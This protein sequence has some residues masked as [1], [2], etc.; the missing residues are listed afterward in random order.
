MDENETCWMI[1]H[2]IE[3]SVTCFFPRESC[4]ALGQ[5]PCLFLFVC[6]FL[7]TMVLDVCYVLLHIKP[8]DCAIY[9]FAFVVHLH[10]TR[11]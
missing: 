7:G 9:M 1:S 2:V 5:V 11:C 8:C 10:R 6:V 4:F 3:L